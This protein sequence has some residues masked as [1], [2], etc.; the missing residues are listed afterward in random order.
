MSLL[1]PFQ[2][3]YHP[4]STLE[5]YEAQARHIGL[6][7]EAT[8]LSPGQ[9]R[10]AF[11]VRPLGNGVLASYQTTH[12][13]GL[14]W[15]ARPNSISFSVKVNTQG[16]RLEGRARA[17]HS[18]L[19]YVEP[20]RSVWTGVMDG[21]GFRADSTLPS[22][23]IS[24]PIEAAALLDIGREKL[25]RGFVEIPM[26]RSVAEAFAHWADRT[27][28]RDT[29]TEDE[30]D[31]LYQW[32]RTFISTLGGDLQLESVSHYT[33]IVHAVLVLSDRNLSEPLS[34]TAMAKKLGLSVRTIQRAFKTTFGVGVS[35]YLRSRR[36]K[37]AHALLATGHISVYRAAHETGFHH[38]PRF[39]QQY[40]R[41]F[42]Y[43]PSDT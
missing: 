19:I 40:R 10:I 32:L 13:L 34:V 11:G 39:S 4:G 37:K 15:E 42:G 20:S 24:V 29:A 25:Q 38:A 9:A 33:R 28:A 36:L 27:L 18:V 35:F 12:Q 17:P 6:Q 41:F 16:M 14:V 21:P 30:Q 8:Q 26:H 23:H 22:Y 7:L 1:Q 2:P 43:P 31:E 5:E 3:A